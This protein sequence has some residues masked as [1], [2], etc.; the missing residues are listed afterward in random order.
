MLTLH[1]SAH[2]A[3]GLSMP[4]GGTLALPASLNADA[5][6]LRRFDH[7]RIPRDALLDKFAQVAPDGTYSSSIPS[8]S[9]RFG[10]VV[11]GLTT[12]EVDHPNRQLS[13]EP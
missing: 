8:L 4:A 6:R 10:V 5:A 9:T 13:S 11:G 2:I 3:M 12:G 7:V 1:T